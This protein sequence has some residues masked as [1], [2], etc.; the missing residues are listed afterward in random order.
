MSGM[1][2]W[3][4]GPTRWRM[5]GAVAGASSVARGL[6]SLD[7]QPRGPAGRRSH[8]WAGGRRQSRLH[9]RR[10]SACTVAL[11][12]CTAAKMVDFGDASALGPSVG[13]SMTP[14]CA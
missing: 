5:S 14:R 9:S 2:Q 11:P 6:G 3:M 1:I 4:I 10:E 8:G 7:D 12:V 13:L